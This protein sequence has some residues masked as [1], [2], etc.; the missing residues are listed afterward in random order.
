MRLLGEQVLR[1]HLLARAQGKQSRAGND[2]V[3]PSA[4]FGTCSQSP[5]PSD[6]CPGTSAP[7]PR[8]NSAAW[9]M[10]RGRYARSRTCSRAS[11]TAICASDTRSAG[12][13]FA[14]TPGMTSEGGIPASRPIA[15]SSVSSGRPIKPLSVARANCAVWTACANWFLAMAISALA[16]DSSTPGRSWFATNVRT[17]VTSTCNRSTF[18]CA[19][20]T[21]RPRQ[22][23]RGTR[24]P[25]PPRRRAR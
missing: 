22:E 11:T 9:S 7:L 5:S 13:A 8:P 15:R 4:Q 25:P 18:A 16:R 3:A 21:P 17:L 23:P 1:F 12:C 20:R 14:S 24:P 19:A 2:T 6:G 10:T